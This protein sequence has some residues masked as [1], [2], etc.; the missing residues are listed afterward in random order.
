[1]ATVELLSMQSRRKAATGRT[2]TAGVIYTLTRAERRRTRQT[3]LNRGK[4]RNEV[5]AMREGNTGGRYL[6]LL[7]RSE[8]AQGA[9]KEGRGSRKAF[10][11]PFVKSHVKMR[12]K[13]IRIDREASHL[14]AGKSPKN[15]EKQE[16]SRNLNDC[17][18]CKIWSG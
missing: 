18:I 6:L 7:V 4:Q 5:Q 2:M 17:G 1:M 11:N 15:I 3:R 10:V 8:A 16:K 14:K 9:Q 12:F 13:A